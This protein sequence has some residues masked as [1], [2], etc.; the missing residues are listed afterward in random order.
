MQRYF[1][2][3]EQWRDNRVTINGDDAHHI[4]RVMRMQI[5]DKIICNPPNSKGAICRITDINDSLV[6]AEVQEW[7]ERE[8]E[9]PVYVTIAQGLPKG[10]KMDLVLQKGTELGAAAF[11]P[12]RADRSVVKWDEKKAEKKLTRFAKI[13]KEASEQSHRNH[14]PEIKPAMNLKELITESE[15]YQVK[16]F[17]YEEEAKTGQFKSFASVVNK[18]IPGESILICI[19]PEG[20]FSSNEVTTLIENN[21]IPVRFGPR[22]LRTETAALYGLASIS[23]HME[24]LEGQSCQQ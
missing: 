7:I 10:D 5:D 2:P 14:L 22:I 6:I 23:Y 16:I 19:G 20:G 4:L 3:D 24:E 17:A 12:F 15:S 21:F 1:I 9:L 18:L 13:V 11:I 8:S